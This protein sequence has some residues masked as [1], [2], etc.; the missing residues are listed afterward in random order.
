MEIKGKVTMLAPKTGTR[1]DGSQ[2]SRPAFLISRGNESMYF[3][4]S[5]DRFSELTR[6]GMA[7]DAEGT[8]KFWQ[9]ADL[10]NG[11]YYNSA[12][13]SS[14]IPAAEQTQAPA[15]TAQPAATAN[16][17]FAAQGAA[18]MGDAF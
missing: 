16:D 13:P 1:K 3:D 2:F 5:E 17:P 9:S 7:A 8:L 18:P 11:R 4:C 14:W 10:Y 12:N 15:Q 6:Q